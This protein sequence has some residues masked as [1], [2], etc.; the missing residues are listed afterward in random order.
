MSDC[1]E[2]VFGNNQGN[3]ACEDMP[4]GTYQ[5]TCSNCNKD[6]DGVLTCNCDGSPPAESTSLRADACQRFVN[7]GGY[8]AC[9]KGYEGKGPMADP[10]ILAA[11]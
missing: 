5:R 9:E 2:G 1:P 7:M 10:K 4:A 6:A 3:L 11:G 8:L